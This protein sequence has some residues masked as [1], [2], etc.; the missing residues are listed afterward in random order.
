MNLT[1]DLNPEQL[2]AIEARSTV[3]EKTPEEF[4]T[5]TIMS[6]IASYTDADFNASAFRLVNAAKDLPF[7]Q[8][9]AIIAQVEQAIQTP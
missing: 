1:L 7:E 9:M 4:L 3:A 2:A 5:D 8:R 6:L